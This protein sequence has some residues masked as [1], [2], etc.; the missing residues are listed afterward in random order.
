MQ[1]KLVHKS[2]EKQ[3]TKTIVLDII[4]KEGKQSLQQLYFKFEKAKINVK[5]H[6]IRARVI[7]LTKNNVLKRVDVAVYDIYAP[8]ALASVIRYPNRGPWGDNRFRGNITGKLIRDLVWFYNP[9][10]VLD[11]MKGSDTTGDVIRGLNESKGM[12]ISYA[13]HDLKEGFDLL[14]DKILGLYDMIIWHPPYYRMIKYSNNLNDLSNCS[15]YDDFL[16]KAEICVKKLMN[17]LSSRGRLVII[18]GDMK[19]NRVYY[20]ISL[21]IAAMKP[22]KVD[23]V[24]IKE[25]YNESSSNIKYSGKFIPIKHETILVYK[26]E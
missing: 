19:K 23:A 5:E 25:Q 22:G 17:A 2:L 4:S 26:G 8:E 16:D 15:N 9:K 1:Q 18:I 20:P 24:I 3:A 10:T 13:G 7:E 12:K 21:D 14:S 6:T 11:P